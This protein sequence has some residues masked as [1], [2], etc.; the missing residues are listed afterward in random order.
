MFTSG[1]GV[2]AFSGVCVCVVVVIV[3]LNTI[4][5]NFWLYN[6]VSITHLCDC[7]LR[8]SGRKCTVLLLSLAFVVIALL[9]SLL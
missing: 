1:V 3:V 9:L 2:V 6:V 5:R 7:G 8:D 4:K